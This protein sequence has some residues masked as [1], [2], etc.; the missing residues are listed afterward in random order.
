VIGCAKE[1]AR[2]EAGRFKLRYLYHFDPDCSTISRLA[3]RAPHFPPSRATGD[4]G[5]NLGGALV[6]RAA[7]APICYGEVSG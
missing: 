6:A 7:L 5:G 3:A 2:R 1:N 4:L